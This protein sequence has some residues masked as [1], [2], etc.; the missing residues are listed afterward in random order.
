MERSELERRFLSEILHG[1]ERLKKEIGYNPTYFTRMVG[2][3]G[4]VEAA[5]RLV[6]TSAPSDGFTKLWE[7]DRLEM[8]IEALILLPWYEELFEETH[9]QAARQRLEQYRFDVD[10]FLRQ[11]SA[12]PPDWAAPAGT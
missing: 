12:S 9:R 11:R 4:P 8:T 7:T 5:R 3:H 2:E 10:G 6:S 1:T